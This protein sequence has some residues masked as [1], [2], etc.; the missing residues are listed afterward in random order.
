MN[1]KPHL[2]WEI[3]INMETSNESLALLN[4]IANDSYKMG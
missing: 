2:A 4:L 1:K 3:Y